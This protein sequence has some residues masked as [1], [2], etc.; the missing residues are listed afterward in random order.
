[1]V[2]ILHVQQESGWKT[3][4]SSPTPVLVDF[5]AEWCA[6]CRMLAPTIEKLAEAYGERIN[7]AKVNVE[8]MPELAS[9]FGIRSIPTLV[10]LREGKL[11]ERIVGLRP[12]EELARL[13][14]QHVKQLSH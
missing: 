9:R 3:I 6:P 10:L 12:Y 1:M 8:E 14:D 2:N 4:E 7:F 13:L 5:W 11:I